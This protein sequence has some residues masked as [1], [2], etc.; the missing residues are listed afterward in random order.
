MA[1]R[2]REVIEDVSVKGGLKYSSLVPGAMK[3]LRIEGEFEG[4]SELG[5][6]RDCGDGRRA[7]NV[8]TDPFMVMPD[9]LELSL[10]VEILLARELARRDS[11]DCLR[12]AGGARVT[13]A[14]QRLICLSSPD[15][16][17]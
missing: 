14:A 11:L 2:T 8:F 6:R 13:S 9:D 17:F 3:A 15:A 16:A 10:R 5:G 1:R 12:G 4:T 7:G